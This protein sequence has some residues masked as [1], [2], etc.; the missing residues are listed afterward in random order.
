MTQGSQRLQ[1]LASRADPAPRD[2]GAALAALPDAELL[3]LQAIARL[4]ARSLPGGD[5]VV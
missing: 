2:V 1:E 3:R 4:R 5:V